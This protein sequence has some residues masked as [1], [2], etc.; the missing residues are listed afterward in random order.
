MRFTGPGKAPGTKNESA[1]TL[2]FTQQDPHSWLDSA[3]RATFP[4]PP[5]TLRPS[6]THAHISRTQAVTAA[7]ETARPQLREMSDVDARKV[8]KRVKAVFAGV[9]ENTAATRSDSSPLSPA[10]ARK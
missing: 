3:K 8:T 1:P 2:P 7:R 9:E 4:S 5:S 10:V 6:H